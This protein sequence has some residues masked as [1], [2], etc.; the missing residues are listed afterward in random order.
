[1]KKLVTLAL[2]ALVVFGAAA[3]ASGSNTPAAEPVTKLDTVGDAM[4]AESNETSWGYSEGTFVYV[5]DNAGTYTRVVAKAP[6]D[7]AAQLDALDASA[8]DYDAKVAELVSPL[9]VDRVEDLSAGMPTQ[10]ELDAY[11][12][13][14][15]QDLLD[16]GFYIQG[17]SV[18][19]GSAEYY[20]MKGLYAYT[21][22]FNESVNL[23]EM[24]DLADLAAEEDPENNETLDAL[25]SMELE[26]LKPL[27]VKSAVCTGVSFD[28]TNPDIAI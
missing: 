17:F 24:P 3:C 21:F 7:V 28:A 14:T 27:T 9:A 22:T 23:D 12:G 13:K 6:E 4:A 25:D 18:N 26:T 15:G 5:F 16:E 1:M 19:G 20:L 8:S 11:K 2:S 10:A